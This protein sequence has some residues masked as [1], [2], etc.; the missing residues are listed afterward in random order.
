M[1]SFNRYGDTDNK[2]WM[3]LNGLST[4]VK[5][6]RLFD[7]NPIGNASI[8]YEMDTQKVFMYDEENHKWLAQN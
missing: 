7:E 1:I 3:E 2:R 6:I 4:D 8:F 5:P